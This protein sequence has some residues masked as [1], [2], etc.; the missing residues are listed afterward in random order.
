MS[1]SNLRVPVD[2]FDH[3]LSYIHIFKD[4][5]RH[6]NTL[7]DCSLVCR[8]WNDITLPYYFKVATISPGVRCQSLCE[9]MTVRP[10]LAGVIQV[11]IF[12]GSMEPRKN[13]PF[14]LI[15]ATNR[16]SGRLPNV[17]S[18]TFAGIYETGRLASRALFTN[19]SSFTKVTQLSILAGMFPY[20]LLFTYISCFPAVEQLFLHNIYE[21]SHD[22]FQ[23]EL[24]F[25]QPTLKRLK[26]KS[27]KEGIAPE[28]FRWISQGPSKHL[29]GD[30]SQ[31][32]GHY[33]GRG[34]QGCVGF[35]IRSKVPM[36]WSRESY[37]VR[38]IFALARLGLF[39]QHIS[40]LQA[41]DKRYIHFSPSI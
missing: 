38:P 21:A 20:R 6:D 2:I 25:P 4:D 40:H 16:L 14:W 27:L 22:E 9:L 31:L 35:K 8:T 26:V 5:D 15:S 37:F 17:R 23:L 28:T 34:C 39:Y 30:N 19:L 32:S 10:V 3:I 7:R 13:D 36:V 1:S 11:L 41:S 24:D 18:I 33:C 29:L 12:Q